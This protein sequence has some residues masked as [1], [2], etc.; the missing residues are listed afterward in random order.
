MSARRMSEGHDDG[1]SSTGPID[2]EVLERIRSRLEPS[3][4]FADVTVRPDDAPES[5]VA[6]YDRHYFPAAVDRAY[7]RIRWYETDDFCFHYSEQYDDGSR[8]E[9]RWD[10]HP[11][12]HNAR[13]HVHPP[14]DAATP[15]T[16]A[17][18]PTD[19]RDVLAAVL[20]RIDERIQAFWE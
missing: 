10:R 17:S 9:V 15:G 4:R 12:D 13:T 6:D 7:L 8:W 19:W 11:N 5:V 14:P 18:L 2:D 1:A 20:C 3:D 16:D